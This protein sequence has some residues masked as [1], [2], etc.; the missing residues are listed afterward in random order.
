[1]MSPSELRQ[2]VTDVNSDIIGMARAVQ[3][4]KEVREEIQ[5]R[6]EAPLEEQL[7]DEDATGRRRGGP[8]IEYV[9]GARLQIWKVHRA[10]LRATDIKGADLYYEIENEKFALVQYKT[11]AKSGRVTRDSGQL[12]VLR[13]SCPQ[14]CPPANRFSCGAWFAVRDGGPGAYLPACQAELVFG[15]FA[16]R[17]KSAFI[18]GLTKEQF[19]SDFGACLIG[20]R[21]LPIDLGAFRQ[22]SINSDHLLFEV[23]H[24]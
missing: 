5:S 21:T 10:G 19:Q 7:I 11:P 14:D 23:L 8:R 20:A 4:R 18:N 17:S 13:Q 2:L 16:S 12:T 1:M 24:T 6:A 3:V 15:S 9:N 22:T